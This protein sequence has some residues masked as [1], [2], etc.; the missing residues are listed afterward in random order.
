VRQE[1]T[2]Y[3]KEI[4]LVLTHYDA[5]AVR[6]LVRQIRT[7]FEPEAVG[8]L[9]HQTGDSIPK[10]FGV[11][12]YSFTSSQIQN[13]GYPIQNRQ[14]PLLGA[15]HY[16]LLKFYRDNPNYDYYWL[17]ENDVRFTGAWRDF[18]KAFELNTADFLSSHIRRFSD[19]PD[20]HWWNSLRH[21]AGTVPE[22]GRLAAFNVIFRISKPA[23]ET[24]HHVLR[25]GWEGHYEVL[26]PTLLREHGFTLLDIGGNGP[27]VPPAFINR[28]YVMSK[29]DSRNLPRAKPRTTMSWRPVRYFAG[30]QRNKLYH[31]VKSKSLLDA[32]KK[33]A[34]NGAVRATA[35]CWKKLN[36]NSKPN[37]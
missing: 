6:Q 25:D 9:W 31:P 36:S 37:G 3:K 10:G 17:I 11:Q 1:N 29:G 22:A 33:S 7:G 12:I 26:I 8:V 27:F 15:K 4:A 5:P 14:T 34:V 23:L 20:W 2:T 32:L 18:F 13:L 30:F 21:P 28:F 19:E 35:Y 24:L 16:P